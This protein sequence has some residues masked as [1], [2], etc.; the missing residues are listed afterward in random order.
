MK[1]IFQFRNTTIL[2]LPE[3]LSGLGSR[4][5]RG[6]AGLRDSLVSELQYCHALSQVINT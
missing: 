6:G 1:K 5:D 3:P 4:W 2:M